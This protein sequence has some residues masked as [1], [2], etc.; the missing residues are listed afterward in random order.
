MLGDT[1]IGWADNSGTHGNI[2]SSN[3]ISA[4]IYSAQ[5]NTG[6]YIARDQYKNNSTQPIRTSQKVASERMKGLVDSYY[7]SSDLMNSYAWDTA[8]LFICKFSGDPTYY[9]RKN[10]SGSSFPWNDW[11]LE[12]ERCNIINLGGCYIE[13]TTEYGV[14][15]DGKYT[16][17]L[18]YRGVETP[19]TRRRSGVTEA[20]NA[21]FRDCLTILH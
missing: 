4:F 15:N 7:S 1:R 17:V 20:S 16:P 10:Y 8:I 18:S 5:K 14:L 19:S 12:F 11:L 13:H 6:F 9:S 2:L 3:D 21:A